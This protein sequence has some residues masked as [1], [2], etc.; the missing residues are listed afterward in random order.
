MITITIEYFENIL[1][2][3]YEDSEDLHN[4][5]MKQYMFDTDKDIF[6]TP[7]P[8]LDLE[9]EIECLEKL[10]TQRDGMDI[11]M[12]LVKADRSELQKKPVE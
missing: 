3:L 11:Y 8:D 2:S 6:I 5:L 10:H 1:D 9:D 7:N 12:Y 4:S